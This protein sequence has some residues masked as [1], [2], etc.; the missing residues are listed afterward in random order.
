MT[1]QDLDIIIKYLE[2]ALVPLAEQHKFVEAYE[3]LVALRRK[4]QTAA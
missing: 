2:K 3:R 1:D 4:L